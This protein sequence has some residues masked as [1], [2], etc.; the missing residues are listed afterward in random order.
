MSLYI[1]I[2]TLYLSLP[3]LTL[4]IL[5]ADPPVHLSLSLSLTH[6]PSHPLPLPISPLP[7][8]FQIRNSLLR[9]IF[10]WTSSFIIYIYKRLRP[11]KK[12]RNRKKERAT[13]TLNLKLNTKPLKFKC[14]LADGGGGGVAG[15]PMQGMGTPT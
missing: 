6:T 3:N 1:S 5:P 4:N 12:I 9:L 13:E 2:S 14:G 10:G 7:L 8:S 15:R 11:R